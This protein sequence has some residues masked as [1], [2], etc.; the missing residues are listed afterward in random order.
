MKISIIIASVFICMFKIC[1][2]L[3]ATMKHQ[4]VLGGK[5]DFSTFCG[6]LQNYMAICIFPKLCFCV[7]KPKQIPCVTHCQKVEFAFFSTGFTL[8][9]VSVFH[10]NSIWDERPDLLP[11]TS[12]GNL[13]EPKIWVMH[14]FPPSSFGLYHQDLFIEAYSNIWKICDYYREF[15]IWA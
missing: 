13:Q 1:I 2:I 11:Q 6:Q 7:S 9:W 5:W 15:Y 12:E 8:S 14:R 3:K 4:N 10:L